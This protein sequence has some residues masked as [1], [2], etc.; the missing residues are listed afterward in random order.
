LTFR[1]ESFWPFLNIVALRQRC[2][3]SFLIPH[4]R[5]FTLIY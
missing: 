1:V 4:S 2:K 3:C 5:H